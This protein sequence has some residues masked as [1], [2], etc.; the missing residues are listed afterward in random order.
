MGKATLARL[1]VLSVMA[2]SAMGATYKCR[3]GSALIG[4]GG[5]GGGGT[6]I[7][8]EPTPVPPSYW[9]SKG[10]QYSYRG[11][12]LP[13]EEVDP[14]TTVLRYGTAS[15]IESH[16]IR[17]GGFTATNESPQLFKDNGWCGPGELSLGTAAGMEICFGL[18]CAKERWHVRCNIVST[19]DPSGFQ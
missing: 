4:G 10:G 7:P 2:L 15:E 3:D 12:C 14:V 9:Q 11:N 18:L 8:P 13:G 16:L 1:L 19:G 6:Y 5:G 17:D